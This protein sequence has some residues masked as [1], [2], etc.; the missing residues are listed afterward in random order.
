MLLFSALNA[1][2]I[3]EIHTDVNLNKTE[4]LHKIILDFD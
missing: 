4:E 3:K 2:A 1:N